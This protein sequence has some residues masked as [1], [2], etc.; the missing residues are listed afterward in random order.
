VFFQA[1]IFDAAL[2]EELQLIEQFSICADNIDRLSHTIESGASCPDVSNKILQLIKD[3][4]Q[5][6][7]LLGDKI[8]VLPKSYDNM[9]DIIKCTNDEDSDND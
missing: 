6:S 1:T 5:F 4:G 9:G 3:F 7:L 8:P 2:K